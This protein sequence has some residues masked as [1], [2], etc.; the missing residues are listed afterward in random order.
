M[1]KFFCYSN[2]NSFYLL[3]L[4]SSITKNIHRKTVSV[5][6][7]DDLDKKKAET[8]AK[9]AISQTVNITI[10]KEKSIQNFWIA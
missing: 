8:P 5:K 7:N 1:S 10:Q 6:K 2:S 4:R 9:I 3:T